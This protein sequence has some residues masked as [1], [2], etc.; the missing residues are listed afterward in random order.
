MA[1]NGMTYRYNVEV[2]RSEAADFRSDAKAAVN[3]NIMVTE[4]EV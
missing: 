1:E 3:I 2:Q 4:S